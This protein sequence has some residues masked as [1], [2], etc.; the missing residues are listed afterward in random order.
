MTEKEYKIKF[1]EIVDWAEKE[2]SKINKSIKNIGLDSNKEK[3]RKI[4]KEY[5][6]KLSKLKEE[7]KQ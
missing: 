1:K 2:T 6:E 5:E 3:Y 4:H 7:F